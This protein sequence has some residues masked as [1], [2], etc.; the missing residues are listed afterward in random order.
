[1]TVETGPIDLEDRSHGISRQLYEN[2]GKKKGSHPERYK[3][4]SH[5][6]Q[7]EAISIGDGVL[8]GILI[9]FRRHPNE[10]P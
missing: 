4:S 9:A 2:G 6:R 3:L 8:E 10:D 1:L 5:F 7:P